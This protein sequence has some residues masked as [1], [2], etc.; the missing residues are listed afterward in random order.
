MSSDMDGQLDDRLRRAF[1]AADLPPAP[2][3]LD[4]VLDGLPRAVPSRRP[5][6]LRWVVSGAMAASLTLVVIAGIGTGWLDRLGTSGGAP[7]PTPSPSASPSPT[8][9]GSPWP[10]NESPMPAF[11]VVQLLAGRA[12]GTIGQGPVVLFGSYSDLRG[13]DG[14]PCPSASTVTLE[15]GCLDRRQGLV[16][17][18]ELVGSI[19]DGRWVPTSGPVVHPYWPETIRANPRVRDLFALVPA[20]PDEA[21]PIFVLLTGHFDDV[22]AAA[23]PVDASPACADRFVVDDVIQATIRGPGPSLNPSPSSSMT[24]GGAVPPTASPPPPPRWM[25]GCAEPR[26]GPGSTPVPGD[27]VNPGYASAGWVHRSEI[28]FPLLASDM[29]PEMVYLAIIDGDVPLT[30]WKEDPDGSATRFRWWGTAVCI[31]DDAG[32]VYTWVPG[33][34]Y[35]RYEDGRRVDGGDPFDHFRNPGASRSPSPPSTAVP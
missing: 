21:V 12:E 24:A 18:D 28:P 30:G 32:I 33:S 4:S 27:P 17:G 3:R 15:I 35:R 14:D 1:R 16:A 13:W 7:S 23:C 25:A 2:S 19:V 26:G 8:P 10:Y 31:A 29:L 5:P 9:S 11:D 34:T 6:L 20:N 22:R